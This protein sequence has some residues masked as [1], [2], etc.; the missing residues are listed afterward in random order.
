[1]DIA[2]HPSQ[3]PEQVEADL[4]ACL[5][6]REIRHKFHYES[7]K[8]AQKWLEVH[9]AHSPARNDPECL[10]LYETA[11]DHIAGQPRP[12]SSTAPTDSSTVHLIGL[13]C[14]GGQKDAGLLQ[15]LKAAGGTI[16]YTA[17][18][19]SVPLVITA[20]LR[21]TPLAQSTAGIVCDLE[22]ADDLHDRFGHAPA[23]YRLFTF[24]GMMPNSE[25][26]VI[27]PR[28][29]QWVRSGDYVLISVNL[30]P[31]PEYL[32]GV[33]RVLPQYDNDETAAWLLTLLYDLGVERDD[34]AIHFRI[35]DS[36]GLLRIRADFQF[37]RPR[38]LKIGRETIDFAVG[39][40]VRLFYSYRYTPARL[41]ATWA[42][43]GL[44]IPRQW[45]S[46]SGEEGI[47]IA[48]KI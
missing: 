32:Q 30:A 26:D 44:A 17:V 34:G 15:R 13:G 41:T 42:K 40:R 12:T 36:S 24:F 2:I 37:A 48:T 47:F 45:I 35:E 46:A 33:K 8:Q 28:L 9:E 21:A 22:T 43:Y 5:R 38:A 31:G 3:F 39:E 20:R 23:V 19:V 16:H 18:D 11:F 10:A 25:P 7:Y 1:M 4:R 27:L 6:A 29:R 14:G